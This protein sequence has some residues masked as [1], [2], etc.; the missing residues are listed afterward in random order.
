MPLTSKGEEIKSAMAKQ[1]GPEKGEKVFYASKNKGTISGVDDDLS[2]V[3][4]EAGKPGTPGTGLTAPRA[5]A[6]EAE[7]ENRMDALIERTHA[8]DRRMKKLDDDC[9]EKE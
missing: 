6:D 5:D 3:T 7:C 9:A 2:E 8:M 4:H 1:Y